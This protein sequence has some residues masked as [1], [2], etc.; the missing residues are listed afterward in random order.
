MLVSPCSAFEPK[1]HEI[2]SHHAAAIYESCTGRALSKELVSAFA[3]GAV[4]EDEWSLTRAINWHFYNND[5]KLGRYWKICHGSNEH[6]FCERYNELE[7]LLA[8]KATNMEIYALAGRIAHHIQDMSSPPHVMPI[9]HTS[10]DKF[11]TYIPAPGAVVDVAAICKEVNGP[12]VE[13]FKMLNDAAQK[14]LKAV[15]HQE[16]ALASGKTDENET[17]MKFWGGPDDKKLSGFKTYGE[18]GN[19]FG[20]IPPCQSSACGRYDRNTF[21]SF[22]ADRYRSAVTDT[23]RLLIYIDRQ[24]TGSKQLMDLRDC[25]I[26]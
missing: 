18:Y 9:Y 7:H 22:Y 11:D 5:K 3:Q 23:V 14:T 20:T 16:I 26:D 13:P 19:I 6:I 17:W 12:V 4:D 8:A 25:E 21:D 1:K 2:F 15:A 10:G 24:N